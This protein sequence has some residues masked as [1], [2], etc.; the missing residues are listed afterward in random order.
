MLS[1]GALPMNLLF[2]VTCGNMLLHS[3]TQASTNV[4]L[5]HLVGLTFA[6]IMLRVVNAA[7]AKQQ[8]A[9]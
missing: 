1:P 7:I 3:V 9:A 6:N 5:C 8:K 4:L 2:A